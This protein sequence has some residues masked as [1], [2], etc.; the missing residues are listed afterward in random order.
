MQ[1]RIFLGFEQNKAI[2][3]HLNQSP[4]W[5]EAKLLG[6]SFLI[7]ISHQE[8]NYIGCFIPE[9]LSLLQIKEKEQEIRSQLQLYC[10]KLSLDKHHSYILSQLFIT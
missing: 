1:I 2:K 5:K 8:K 9:F 3:I 7:E 4:L 10:P 6:A